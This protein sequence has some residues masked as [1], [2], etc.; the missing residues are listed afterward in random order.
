MFD[1][2]ETNSDK[3]SLYPEV[4]DKVI[5]INLSTR[6]DRRQKVTSDFP[7]KFTFFNATP[8]ENPEKGCSE[9]HLSVIKYAKENNYKNIMIIEDDIKIIKDLTTVPKFPENYHMLY[10][11]GI[12]I[13]YFDKKEDWTRGKII[14]AHAYI[15]NSSF[16]D[17]LIKNIESTSDK[18][19][20]HI[21]CDLAFYN[22]VYMVTKTLIGQN[23]DYSDISKKI[24]WNGFEW[25]NAGDRWKLG[26]F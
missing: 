1:C 15:V 4:V 3:D 2:F 18:P 21:Y 11:G 14:C 13:E 26:C 9:S 17:I 19:I 6:L 24:K 5:C 8:H 22:N 12:C 25:P 16:Y 20:D 23:S 10:L 7:Y